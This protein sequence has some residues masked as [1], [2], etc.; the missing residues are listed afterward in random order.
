MLWDDIGLPHER[1]KQIYGPVIKIIGFWVNPRDMTIMMPPSM[2][3]HLIS[4]VKMFV[5]T[6][7]SH[8]CPLFEWQWMLG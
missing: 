7:G 3:S 8:T 4:A 1:Q 2:K 6:M 5:D